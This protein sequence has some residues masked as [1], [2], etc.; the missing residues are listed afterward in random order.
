MSFVSGG[1]VKT[2]PCS[3][4]ASCTF[5]GQ[6]HATQKNPWKVPVFLAFLT[7]AW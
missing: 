1:D 4:K 7:K 3:P 2:M 6:T 5:F